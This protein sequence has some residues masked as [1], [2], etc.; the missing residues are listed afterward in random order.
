MGQLVQLAGALLILAAF[1][2]AQAGFLDQRSYRYLVA[3][4]AG[5]AVLAFDAWIEGQL[6]F[7]V[8][9]AA[10]ALVSVWSLGARLREQAPAR[11]EAGDQGPRMR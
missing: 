9:E 10:W 8:L 11:R 2:L 7:L 5:A 4:I 3:N 6:G 1:V